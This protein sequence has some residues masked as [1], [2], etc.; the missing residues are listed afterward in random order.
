M[1]CDN[2]L[3]LRHLSGF[4]VTHCIVVQWYCADG[5]AVARGEAVAMVET[6]KVTAEL[7]APADGVLRQKF[8]EGEYADIDDILGWVEHPGFEVFEVREGSAVNA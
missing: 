1:S 8:R 2:G 4:Q 7:K 6:S 5:A 3:T